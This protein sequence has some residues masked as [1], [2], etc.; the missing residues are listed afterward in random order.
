MTHQVIA[1]A[2]NKGLLRRLGEAQKAAK[3]VGKQGRNEKQNYD[4]ARAEDVIAEAR[5][6]LH[7]AGLVATMA[8]EDVKPL[9][10][11]SKNGGAGIF[12]TLA[13]AL[14]I[15]CPET[16]ETLEVPGFGSGIDYPGDKA[17][18]KAMTGAAKYAYASA[19]G[20]P[21]GDD[22][23]NDKTSTS[24]SGGSGAWKPSDKQVDLIKR[25][26]EKGGAKGEDLALLIDWSKN[27][28]TGGKE[29]SASKAIDSLMEDATVATERLLTA[30]RAWAEKQ[31]ATEYA[32]GTDLPPAD[33][34]DDDGTLL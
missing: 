29:G 13:G 22:P 15:A 34:P 23:E 21:F 7:S 19:L 28:L 32:D 20:I 12:I 18:Y 9:E 2:R 31:A 25:K 11:T 24:S 4:Y 14:R 33:A 1:E 30:A 3:T 5:N 27:V 8:F 16:G 17:V 26:A 10:V 6:A